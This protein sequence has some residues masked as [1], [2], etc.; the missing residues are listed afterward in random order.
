MRFEPDG[1]T[2]RNFIFKSKVKRKRQVRLCEGLPDVI[3]DFLRV[4]Q[5]QTDTNR[6]VMY[7]HVFPLP[8]NQSFHLFR[9]GEYGH[10]C[11]GDGCHSGVECRRSHGT[12]AESV[13]H[14]IGRLKLE[15][16]RE[17]DGHGE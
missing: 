17:I 6:R 1:W 7:T 13:T 2:P 5:P 14:R 16:R 11:S 9:G 3:Q 12:S 15:C 8:V 10:Q 4:F